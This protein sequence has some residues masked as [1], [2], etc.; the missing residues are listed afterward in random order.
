M[1]NIDYDAKGQ[2]TRIEYSDEDPGDAMADAPTFLTEYSY[3]PLTFRLSQLLTTRVSDS[4]VLQDLS[5]TLDPV[6]NIVRIIDDAQQTT[7]FNNAVVLPENGY[8]YD[9]V[10]RL[11][12]A[13][14]REH[15]SIGDVQ[16]DD[17]DTA[18]VT[19]PHANMAD[20]VRNYEETFS[21]DKIGNILSMFHDAEGSP[22]ACPQTRWLMAS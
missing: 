13:T 21:Y 8:L 18:I 3:D 1:R 22:Q 12:K 5:Y 15:A 7:F 4:R 11:I 14:G 9:A 10:Y 6:G 20:A 16:V 17:T 2:R 19:L